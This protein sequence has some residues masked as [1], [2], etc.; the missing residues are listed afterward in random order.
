MAKIVPVQKWHYNG[1][2]YQSKSAAIEANEDL[3][4]QQVARMINSIRAERPNSTLNHSDNIA[5][6]EYLLAHRNEL[7]ELLD[8][9]IDNG[10]D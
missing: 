2:D 9:D 4:S 8:L 3:I 5:I 6:T 10:D 1:K 7:I